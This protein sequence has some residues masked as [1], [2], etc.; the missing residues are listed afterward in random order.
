MRDESGVLKFHD[1]GI[2]RAFY[3]HT[4]LLFDCSVSLLSGMPMCPRRQTSDTVSRW[5]ELS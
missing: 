1:D 2:K 5:P 4:T 3:P